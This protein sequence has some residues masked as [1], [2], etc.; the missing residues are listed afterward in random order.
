[1]IILFTIGTIG[2]LMLLVQAIRIAFSLIKIVCYII[3]LI[4]CL[5]LLVLCGFGL[6]CQW[7]VRWLKRGREPEPVLTI[8]FTLDN[9]E[10]V[11]TIE[12]SRKSFHRLRG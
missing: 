11:P 6:F 9:D 4:G 12:L 3:A 10:D 1:M 8:N 5:V 2:L 7:I